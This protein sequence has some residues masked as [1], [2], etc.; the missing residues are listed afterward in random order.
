MAVI[1]KLCIM[2]QERS[3][4]APCRR[5]TRPDR[6]SSSA[7]PGRWTSASRPWRR[8]PAR[9]LQPRAQVRVPQRPARRL[10][11]VRPQARRIRP[12][13]LPVPGQGPRLPP[14]RDW[15]TEGQTSGPA[16]QI[17]FSYSGSSQGVG[18]GFARADT[19][20]LFQAGDK[21]LAVADLAGIG[22]LLD[23]L[24][25]ALQQLGHEGH[26]ELHFGQEVDHIL[27]AAIQL[28]VTL[29]PPKSLYFRNRQAGDADGR[30]G[31][32]HFVQLERLDDCRYGGRGGA[33]GGAGGGGGR[34]GGPP[35]GGS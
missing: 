4:S 30:Q 13:P 34:G 14:E 29:L 2:W 3:S 8:N 12:Q 15:E 5:R 1:A 16:K 33:R 6:E 25:H 35:R 9:G 19:H 18:T 28:G 22:R 21:N 26:L 20:D 17:A 31:L 24:D 7:A 11:P 10:L 23:G 32:A 27:R